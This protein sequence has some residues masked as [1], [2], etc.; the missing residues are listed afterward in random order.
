M[1]TARSTVLDHW[2]GPCSFP[3]IHLTIQSAKL[4]RLYQNHRWA[5]NSANH[6]LLNLGMTFFI[7]SYHR[8]DSLTKVSNRY[9]FRTEST[10]PTSPS[11][12][13]LALYRHK[14]TM[15]LP[16]GNDAT[17]FRYGSSE[18][19]FGDYSWEVH[20]GD[21]S[22]EAQYRSKLPRIAHGLL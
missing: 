13:P 7:C 8:Y 16:W 2:A 1:T 9:A 3:F 4:S 20:F 5:P 12:H 15:L 22:W 17:R 6:H 18:A 19:R 10:S 21:Y 14:D 11:I